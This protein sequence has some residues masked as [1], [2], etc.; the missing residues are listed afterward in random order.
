MLCDGK[1]LYNHFGEL[2]LTGFDNTLCVALSGVSS[3]DHDCGS[4]CY[5]PPLA[6]YASAYHL[7][8]SGAI[9]GTRLSVHPAESWYQWYHC[10][11]LAPLVPFFDAGTSHFGTT[12]TTY[13][14]PGAKTG[15]TGI[16]IWHQPAG[17]APLVP[18]GLAVLY[19][20]CI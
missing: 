18:V 14:C 11:C 1:Y 17:M 15:T 12:G 19:I 3:H 20:S 6:G 5:F 10:T 2:G 4:S 9:A 8:L 13:P 7:I 16:K